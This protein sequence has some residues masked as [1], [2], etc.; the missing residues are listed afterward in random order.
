MDAINTKCTLLI[1]DDTD[2]NIDILVEAFADDYD[3][4][5]ATD[6]PS[7]LEAVEKVMPDL[8]LLDVMMPGMD[9]FE[10]CRRLKKETRFEQIPIIFLTAMDQLSSKEEGFRVGGVDYVTKPFDILEVKARVLTHISLLLARRS[11]ANQN[12]VLEEKVRE[13][14]EEL[15]HTQNVTIA[16]LASLAETRDN[17]TGWHIKRSK[18]YIVILIESLKEN[19]NFGELKDREI[20]ELII[21]SAPLHD[22]GKIGVPDSILLKP[23]PLTHD[24]FEEMKKHTILG[25]EALLV[26]E[27]ELGSNSFLRIAAEMCRSH[28]EKWNGEGYP[29]GLSGRGIPLAGRLMAVADVYDALISSRVYKPPFSHADATTIILEGKGTHFDPDIIDAYEKVHRKFEQIATELADQETAP[30]NLSK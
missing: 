9:G 13:R 2:S 29:D 24:E 7:T 10:V 26:A 1:S 12:E 20:E 27:R 8:I 18:A 15:N 30:F 23:G 5:V 6:G 22:I 17:E 16:S 14:T 4:M 11:L 19:P 3:V 25:S 21:K 28:H